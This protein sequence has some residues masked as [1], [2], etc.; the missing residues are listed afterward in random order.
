MHGHV[1]SSNALGL[2]LLSSR[3][4]WD[5]IGLAIENGNY[6]VIQTSTLLV[7]VPLL[8]L[9]QI[10]YTRFFFSLV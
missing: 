8:V 2:L 9:F 7:F 5:S 3:S 6:Q 1:A 10:L 4:P